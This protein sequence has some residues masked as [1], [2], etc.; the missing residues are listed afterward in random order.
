M[1]ELLIGKVLRLDEFPNSIT[2][3]I[4]ILSV[5][6]TLA[7]GG[8]NGPAAVPPPGAFLLFSGS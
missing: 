7:G 5:L 3:E 1:R 8:D 2:K 6:D 4:R